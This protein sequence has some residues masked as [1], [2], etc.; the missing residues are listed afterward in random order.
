[1]ELRFVAS[2]FPFDYCPFSSSHMFISLFKYALLQISFEMLL[3]TQILET[4]PEH[5]PKRI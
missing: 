5:N 2:L 1:M 4:K 3:T